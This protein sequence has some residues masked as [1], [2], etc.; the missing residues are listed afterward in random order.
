MRIQK[1]GSRFLRVLTPDRQVH[2]FT[3]PGF[4]SLRVF[5]IF[6]N[7]SNIDGRVLSARQLRLI[8]RICNS[9]EIS[10]GS[11]DFDRLIG[12]VELS[13]IPDQGPT[14]S[15]SLA[16]SPVQLPPSDPEIADSQ[17]VRIPSTVFSATAVLACSLLVV[18]VFAN[19]AVRHH[20]AAAVSRSFKSMA[21]MLPRAARE[22][23]SPQ[24]A[25]AQSVPE[26]SL[27]KVGLPGQQNRASSGSLDDSARADVSSLFRT[28]ETAELRPA[29]LRVALL[30]EPPA[31]P[32]RNLQPESSAMAE[33]RATTS[34]RPASHKPAAPAPGITAEQLP[35][36][37]PPKSH[38]VPDDFPEVSK[39]TKVILR[40]IISADGKVAHV[41]VVEGDPAL[42]REAARAVTSWRY[43]PRANSGDAESHIVFQ[44]APDVTT[45]SFLNSGPAKIAR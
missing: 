23:N 39:D 16:A 24:Q 19:A 36:S 25:V 29:T 10:R 27:V 38:P 21:S 33:P 22:S 3:T 14:K 4:A 42:A 45:V 43:S 20:M 26:P 34:A 2:Y 31:L 30:N 17:P 9:T 7:F 32:I 41:H 13:T 35:P 8:Q 15:K 12:T 28:E 5:W 18:T 37:G 1:L 44:F 40:A 6:R 11:V